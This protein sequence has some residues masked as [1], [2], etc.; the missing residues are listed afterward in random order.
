M[1]AAVTPPA[2]EPVTA[3]VAAPVAVRPPAAGLADRGDRL[4]AQTDVG[5]GWV[6]SAGAGA[7]KTETLVGRLGTVLGAGDDAGDG[8]AA[9]GDGRRVVAITFTE[10]AARDL[11]HKIRERFGD[12]FAGEQMFVGTIHGFCLSILRRF[13]LEAGLPPVFR[14]ES[15]MMTRV[16]AAGRA[17][18]TRWAFF[19]AV[20][21]AG[22]EAR[23][24]VAALVATNAM[25]HFDVLVGAIERDWDRFDRVTLPTPGAWRSQLAALDSVIGILD[26]ADVPAGFRSTLEAALPRLRGAR[27]ARTLDKAARFLVD[28]I[29]PGN[30]K[31]YRAVFDDGLGRARRAVYHAA[32]AHVLAL[33]VPIVVRAARERQRGG[34]ISFD[35]ILVLTRVLLETNPRVLRTVRAE[36]AHLCVDEFQDTDPV[37]YAI[38]RLLTDPDPAADDGDPRP[39]LFA[40]GDPKQSIYAFRN[41]DVGLFDELRSLPHL[42]PGILS[43]NFRSRPAI[44]AWVNDVFGPWFGADQGQVPFQALDAQVVDAPAQVHVLGGPIDGPSAEAAAAQSQDIVAVIAAAHGSWPVR[45]G[46]GTR[47]ARYGDVAVLVRRRADLVALEPRLVAAGIPYVIEGGTLRYETREVRDLLRVLRAVNDPSSPLTVVT[48][49]RTSVLAVSDVEL[50]AHRAEPQSSW[51]PSADKRSGDPAVLR[52]FAQLRR[53]IRQRPYTPPPDILATIARDG[54]SWAASASDPATQRASWR[55]L[56]TVIDEARDWF[57][58]TG[59]SLTDYL[60]FVDAMVDEDERR[61]VSTD[62]TDDDAVRV[63]TVHAAKGLDFPIV[64]AAGLGFNRPPADHTRARFTGDGVEVKMGATLRTAGFSADSDADAARREAAR[65]VYVACTRARDHLVVCVHYGK[66]SYTCVAREIAPFVTADDASVFPA[67]DELEPPPIAPLD[68]DV[69]SPRPRRAPWT[70]RSSIAATQV[71]TLPRADAAPAVGADAAPDQHGA[72]AA[73]DQP[74]VV[75]SVHSKPPRSAAALPEQV[76]RYGTVIGRA[77]HGVM[78]HVDLADPARDRQALIALHAAAEEV[79]VELLGYV[80]DL[81]ASLVAGQAFARMQAA[82]HAGTVRREMYV[83]GQVADQGVYGIIDAVWNT[84]DGFV[85][86]DFKTDHAREP[87][88]VLRARYTAQLQSYALAL[89]AATGRPV[90]EL[91]LSVAVADGSP[92]VTLPIPLPA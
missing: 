26:N 90:A 41:A 40:V 73:P 5:S 42:Q 80:G 50:V 69:A 75:D 25:M 30:S 36:I 33:L 4:A 19:E 15:E 88:A 83:G 68:V 16:D 87:D 12:T 72:D 17:R 54:F 23:D 39:V 57:Q 3:P 11:I 49:L 53:W 61:N 6:L 44:L 86:V 76:G 59:G 89:T 63:L 32:L 84:A 13:P 9:P 22:D 64:V 92:A 29:S 31:T 91:L 7:G 10:R 74:A 51:D 47:A 55:R 2:T 60:A 56:R 43:A 35:D 45:D 66:R 81:V 71:A 21:A 79:P 8:E 34:S 48:A 24:A 82:H 67:V 65:L 28:D 78:Q 38:V 27:D 1:A 46:D 58:Q 62:E 37:Q 70:I 85:V 18:S 77:V 20:A 14:T 52:A